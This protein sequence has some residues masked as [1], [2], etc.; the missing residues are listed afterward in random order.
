M[1]TVY[2]EGLG[3]RPPFVDTNELNHVQNLYT[4][5]MPEDN[6]FIEDAK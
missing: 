1:N 6:G 2:T 5:F 4:N 3:N